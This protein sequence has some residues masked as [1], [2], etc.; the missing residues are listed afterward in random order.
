MSSPGTQG[1]PSR[2]EVSSVTLV[3]KSS[4]DFVYVLKNNKS[5]FSL[6]HQVMLQ[7]ICMCV[8]FLFIYTLFEI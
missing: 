2:F 6:I 5:M 7:N 3:D 8:L 1:W 4:G